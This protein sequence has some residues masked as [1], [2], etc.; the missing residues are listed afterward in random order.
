VVA[1]GKVDNG[2]FLVT[3]PIVAT[4]NAGTKIN[5][6]EPGVSHCTFPAG[7]RVKVEVVEQVHVIQNSTEQYTSSVSEYRS[8]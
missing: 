3:S 4:I 1:Y 8:I 7:T 6:C 2:H 5:L